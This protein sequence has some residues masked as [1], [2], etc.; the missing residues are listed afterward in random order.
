[1][2]HQGGGW[3]PAPPS[4]GQHV[5]VNPGWVGG[6]EQSLGS[7]PS[8]WG[9]PDPLPQVSMRPLILEGSPSDEFHPGVCVHR[10]R[11][12]F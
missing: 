12:S 2:W 9:T 1:M 3:V 10:A 11:P 7:S 6:F 4:V 8:L 5:F